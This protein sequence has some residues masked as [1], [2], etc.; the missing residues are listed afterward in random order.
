VSRAGYGRK[1]HEKPMGTYILHAWRDAMAIVDLM[2]DYFDLPKARTIY[3]GIETSAL[4]E[5]EEA[6]Y[7]EISNFIRMT[8]SQRRSF[9]K[10]FQ[11]DDRTKVGF[12]TLAVIGCL[13]SKA[14]LELR[15]E[16]RLALAPGCGNRETTAAVYSFGQRLADEL[17]SYDWPHEVISAMGEHDLDDEDDN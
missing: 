16:Y 15:D 11:K 10:K 5:Y 13:R 17:C 4:V 7:E 12:L 2:Q 1:P 14:I 9:M 8:E 6:T 3:M